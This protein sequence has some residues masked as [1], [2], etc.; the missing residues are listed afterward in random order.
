MVVDVSGFDTHT[1]NV[2]AEADVVVLTAKKLE[3]ISSPESGTFA[4][5]QITKSYQLPHPVLGEG[6]QC[7]LD[8][9]VLFISVPWRRL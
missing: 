4:E 8:Q 6:L 5:R 7:S 1:L 2:R 3:L 9:G